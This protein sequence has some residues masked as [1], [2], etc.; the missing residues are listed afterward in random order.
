MQTTTKTENPFVS[1]NEVIWGFPNNKTNNNLKPT[2]ENFYIAENNYLIFN[3]KL[4][5]YY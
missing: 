1:M 5:N 2:L 3:K 4:S